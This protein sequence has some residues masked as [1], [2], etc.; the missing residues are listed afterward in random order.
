LPFCGR[1]L[2]QQEAPT[3][4]TTKK[5]QWPVPSNALERIAFSIPE[6]C[7]RNDISRTAYHRLRSEG[8]GPRETRFGLNLIRITLE[9]E[10]EWLHRLQEESADFETQAVERAVKAGEAAVRSEKHISKTRLTRSKV[11]PPDAQSPCVRAKRRAAA[12][13]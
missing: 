3:V 2:Q 11:T 8:R 1:L 12:E 10:R 13:T 4:G 7:F 9:D 5:P 6:I